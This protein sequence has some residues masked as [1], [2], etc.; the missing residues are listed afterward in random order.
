MPYRLSLDIGTN[1]VGWCLLDLGSSGEPAG[2][3]DAGVVAYADGRDPQ[4]GTS[5][6]VDRRTA[7]GA[8]RN[9]DR[10]ILRK[11]DLMAALIAHGLMPRDEADRKAL[12][13]EDPYALR[14]R[15]LDQALPAD[16]VGRALFHLH[17]RR[18]FKSNRKTDGE[19][20]GKIRTANQKLVE[21]MAEA[22]CRTLGEYLSKLHAERRGVRARLRGQGA[23]AEY[24]LYATRDMVEEEF[25]AIWDKQA[26]HH[27]QMTDTAKAAVHGAMFRQRPLKA[28][29]VGRCTFNPEEE[30]LPRAHPLFQR[31]RIL[32][33]LAHLRL[34]GVDRALTRPERDLLLAGLRE[35]P[36]LT[37]TQIRKTLKLGPGV[38]INL[39]DG[40]RKGLD[41][42]QTADVLTRKP[43]KDGET[44]PFPEWRSLLSDRQAAI[45]ERLLDDP[46]E[47]AL[48]A[49]LR[50]EQGRSEDQAR[51]AARRANGLPSGHGHLGPTALAE[52]V[53]VMEAQGLVFADAAKEA[54]YHHSDFRPDGQAERLAYYGEPLSRHVIPPADP[55]NAATEEERHG[56]LPNPTVHIGLNR[57]RRLVNALIKEHGKPAQIVVELARELKQSKKQREET[58]RRQR[59]NQDKNDKRAVRLAELGQP[60]TGE[61]RL[62]LR[63]WEELSA[64]EM[65]R[66]CPYS[67]ERIT[68]AML[69]TSEVDIDHILPFSQTLDNSVAN[70][71]VC[72]RGANRRKG[73]RTPFEAFGMDGAWPKMLQQAQELPQNK[74][75]RFQADAMERFEKNADFL[76]RQLTDTQYLARVAVEY[77]GQVVPPNRIWV[78]PGRLTAMLRGRWGLNEILFTGNAKE[79]TDH[80]HHAV[81][82]LV[83]GCTSRSM[84]NRIARVA[85]RAEEQ[86]LDR[87]LAEMPPPWPEFEAQ[88][89]A[90]KTLFNAIVVHHRPEHS[91]NGKLHEET[92]YGAVKDHDRERGNLVVRKPLASL[93]E[94]QLD[95]IR[96]PVLRDAVKR[97]VAEGKAD[98]KDMKQV[99]A[100]FEDP[101]LPA[102]GRDRHVHRV[103]LLKREAEEGLVWM[104]ARDGSPYKAYAK[105]DIHRIEV[106]AL[107]DGSWTG[108]PVSRFDAAQ[109]AMAQPPPGGRLV[110]VLHKN[111]LVDV[112]I[113]G[114]RRL[115]RV[116]SLEPSAK[117]VRLADHHIAGNPDTRHMDKDDPFTRVLA[118][119]TKLRE[120]RARR[121]RVDVLGR[122]FGVRPP[123]LRGDGAATG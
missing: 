119:Y 41:G 50:T 88:R 96:D 8:R 49:W 106:F 93:S 61:N 73:N 55:R 20:E 86:G 6:A 57:V 58:E 2:V 103:R 72:L 77:L 47:A 114:E 12:E 35:K 113:D 19:D 118:S 59:E 15:A 100:T 33:D 45:V 60:N 43:R 4:S 122:V 9:R 108:V 3:R 53:S 79:R 120:G 123:G 84:L 44:I 92:A 7:R 95:D 105:G 30:R 5:L 13:A 112:A 78:V 83:V 81:D 51:A 121:V 42:D 117:R 31:F 74:R 71:T 97:A 76:D 16:H 75:W 23:K 66:R 115:M 54:G 80:R 89:G 40:K 85:A 104:R 102:D 48:V 14:S 87:L 94:K 110:M 32:S 17:Q 22:Q 37:F 91:A 82:A 36:K 67:L 68:P 26:L 27:E 38:S 99:L 90:L 101:R 116:Y 28:P 39:E 24:D 10:G 21:A 1:S 52:I 65:D 62:R 63:L 34:E 18:G 46:D 56:R 29:P 64:D 70:R 109:G 111:D 107:S 98:G 11:T 25:E 69:F